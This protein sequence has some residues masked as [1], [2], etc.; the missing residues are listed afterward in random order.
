MKKWCMEM[1]MNVRR[2]EV[3]AI[4]GFGSL[5]HVKM[6]E[7]RSWILFD[8]MQGGVEGLKVAMDVAMLLWFYRCVGE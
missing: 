8:I 6:N 7:A 3:E 4:C 1:V 2:E 5:M